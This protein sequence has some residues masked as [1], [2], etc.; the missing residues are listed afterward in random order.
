MLYEKIETG[1]HNSI[2]KNYRGVKT[3]VSPGT[4]TR[5]WWNQSYAVVPLDLQQVDFTF[6]HQSSD[7]IT[8]A[9]KGIIEFFISEPA[10]TV[11]KFNFETTETGIES[12]KDKLRDIVRGELRD[13][14]SS[15][16]MDSAIMQRSELLTKP[17]QKR[18]NEM[19]NNS[20]EPWGIRLVVL[21]QQVFPTDPEIKRQLQ[22]ETKNIYLKK[23]EAS[24]IETEEMIQKRTIESQKIID[25][26]NFNAEREKYT[27]ENERLELELRKKEKQLQNNSQVKKLESEFLLE[28]ILRKKELDKE[29][30]LAETFIEQLTFDEQIKRFESE[31]RMLNI[32]KEIEELKSEIDRIK[33]ESEIR[34]E[35]AFAEI[36]KEMIPLEHMTEIA[37]SLSNTFSG[38]HLSIY[39]DNSEFM[40]PVS[41]IADFI[42]DKISSSM[43]K[44]E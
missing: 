4:I 29:K 41:F 13:I 26:E 20:L 28:E 36:R 23:E 34:R 3:A 19:V 38:A 12:I 39:G 35:R 37:E 30:I 40:K 14:A 32:Q 9:Y 1:Q 22:A 44:K 11:E 31:K 24:R 42:L 15:L 25:E 5:I 17:L 43:V 6:S 8:M 18:M 27:R 16:T 7:F 2:V 10:I 33:V 21:V